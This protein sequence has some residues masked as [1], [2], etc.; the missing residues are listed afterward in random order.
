MPLA[1]QSADINGPVRAGC[2]LSVADQ[3]AKSG[4]GFWSVGHGTRSWEL[5]KKSEG[6]PEGG[7]RADQKAIRMEEQI[8]GMGTDGT[9][10]PGRA[11]QR[12]W[13]PILA[14]YPLHLPRGR[15]PWGYLR[16]RLRFAS[17]GCG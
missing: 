11:C 13:G 17:L 16:L 5:L 1:T 15:L 12:G 9:Y 6:K 7:R 4:Q 14:V 3:P 2:P 10:E 8:G